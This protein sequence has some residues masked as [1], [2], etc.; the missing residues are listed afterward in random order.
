M[1]Y[2][3]TTNEATY[4]GLTINT[5][6]GDFYC[7]TQILQDIFERFNY[8]TQKHNKVLFI[9]FDLHFPVG[10]IHDGG[11]TEV[12][13]LFKLLKESLLRRGIDTQYVWV[14]EQNFQNEVPHY[15]AILLLNGNKVQNYFPIL[16]KVTK[17]WGR[18]LGQN[19]LGCVNYCNN[20]NGVPVDNGIMIRRPSSLAV[21]DEL[22]RQQQEYTFLYQHCFSWASYLAKINQKS[23]TP[24]G[25][26]R[27]NSS[28]IPVIVHS[29]V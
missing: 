16:A 29:F 2:Q 14:R 10:Y 3:A 6:N 26:R 17:T 25:V 27:F 21:G 1:D 13:L 19:A 12:S 11:N 8:M 4:Q 20:C 23:F 24:Y 9:R 22:L 18:I 5:G 28:R 15:H 7:F